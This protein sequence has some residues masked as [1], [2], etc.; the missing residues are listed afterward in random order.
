MRQRRFIGI[1]I[2]APVPLA[3]ST[4][5]LLPASLGAAAMLGAVFATFCIAW[6]MALTVAITGKSRLL[7]PAALLLGAAALAILVACAGGLGSPALLIIAALPLEAW[8]LHRTG[9]ATLFGA[10]AALAV[11]PAQAI[12]A[13]LLPV[14]GDAGVSAWLAVLA[15][16]AFLAPRLAAWLDETESGRNV[17]GDRAAR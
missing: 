4:A 5:L 11:I 14:Q 9:K 13:Q 3:V 10:T 12:A 8:W 17:G 2:A 16:A 15:Y 7:E 1:L 6:L